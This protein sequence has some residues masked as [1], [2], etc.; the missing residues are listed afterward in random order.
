MKKALI[1]LTVLASAAASPFALAQ[2]AYP[3]KPIRWV[4]PYPA[5]GGSDFMARTAAAQMAVELGQNILVDNKPGGN[6]AIAVQ[7]ILRGGPDGYAV[8]KRRQWPPGVSTPCST[9]ASPTR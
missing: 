9:R 8:M 4:V 7:D 3:T 6:G 5:G 1:A 2:S